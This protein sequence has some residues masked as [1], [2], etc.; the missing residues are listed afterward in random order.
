[1]KNII[2]LLCASLALSSCSLSP[3][4]GISSYEK[5]LMNGYVH[6]SEDIPL[7]KSLVK[8]NS[9]NLGFNSNSGSIYSTSYISLRDIDQVKDF[10]LRTMP[11]LGWRITQETLDGFIYV[12]GKEKVEITFKEQNGQKFVRFLIS[13]A[14]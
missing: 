3:K 2:L 7:I 14:V 12:R 11:Q 13:S 6:G 4:K 5:D 9:G 1:M 8:V 10:Y